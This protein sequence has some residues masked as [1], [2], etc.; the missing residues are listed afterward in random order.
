VIGLLVL[1]LTIPHQPVSATPI[2]GE[3]VVR[4]YFDP[5]KS[6]LDKGDRATL[7]A[8]IPTLKDARTIRVDGFVQAAKPGTGT[9]R[10]L[11]RDR[12]RSV[13]IYLESSF[14]KR[15][16]NI[17]VTFAGKGRPKTNANSPFARRAEVIVTSV[18]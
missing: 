7:N 1:I 16:W 14:K 10:F 8:I 5:L 6:N 11:S 15:R 17:E 3:P 18:N 12:A 13:A 4:I 2:V 9:K